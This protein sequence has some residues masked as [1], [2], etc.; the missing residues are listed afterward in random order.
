[1]VIVKKRLPRDDKGRKG[2]VVDGGGEEEL[3]G[4]V[5][6]AVVGEG[7]LGDGAIADRGSPDDHDLILPLNTRSHTRDVKEKGNRR[8][9]AKR[10]RSHT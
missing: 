6:E 2:T 4:V 8:R 7:V 9:D 3:R 5:V 10:T 1:M